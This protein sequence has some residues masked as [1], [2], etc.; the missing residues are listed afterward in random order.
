MSGQNPPRGFM[1]HAPQARARRTKAE[2]A[3]IREAIVAELTQD[4]PQ[5]VRQL[6]YRLVSRGVISKTEEEYQRTVCRLLADMRRSGEIP[7]GWIADQTRWMRRPVTFSSMEDAIR[8]TAETYRQ[9]LWDAATD[10][11][12][13]WCEKAALSGV[14]SAETVAW[15][16]ALMICGGYPSMSFLHGAAEAI[17]ERSQERD[18]RTVIY[19]FGDHDPSGVDIDRAIVKGIGQSLVS[20]WASRWGADTAEDFTPEDAFDEL[21][22]FRRV[23]VTLGQVKALSLQTRPTKRNPRDYRAKGFVG[24]S[25]EVDAI[26]ARTLRAIAANCI[27]RHVDQHQLEVL[28]TVEAEERKLLLSMADQIGGAR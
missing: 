8:R 20:I 4:S 16:V 6:F 3:A 24:D 1:G 11:P 7:Y 25:V 18:Q 15:D 19:Y 9:A 17:W 10:V 13:I 2:M 28:Q 12:E 5:T 27:E 23:A 21:A 14:L 22:D 26:Q